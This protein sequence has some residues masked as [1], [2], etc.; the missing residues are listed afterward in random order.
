MPIP[1]VFYDW[2][3]K[4]PE[5]RAI[6]HSAGAFKADRMLGREV[7]QPLEISPRDW[8]DEVR[9]RLDRGDA[10]DYVE[11]KTIRIDWNKVYVLAGAPA[12]WPTENMQIYDDLLN[13]LT[14]RIEPR[15]D[16]EII[17]IKL[18]ADAFWEWRRLACEKSRVPARSFKHYQA[19]EL[20]QWRAMKRYNTALCQI[21]R[22]RKALGGEAQAI[23]RDF[24]AEPPIPERFLDGET[25]DEIGDAAAA[26]A[27]VSPDGVAKSGPDV[28]PADVAQDAADDRI[29]EIVEALR[30][31]TS[32]DEAA[33][34]APP[35][36]FAHEVEI[37]ERGATKRINWVAWLTGT[38]QYPFP[39]LEIAGEKVFK[40]TFH[41]RRALVRKLVLDC[42]II[43][44]DQVCPHFAEWLE[45]PQAP[46]TPD[47][48]CR[49]ERK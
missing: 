35:R 10:L 45:S 49:E 48:A 21:E 38:K 32:P 8:E 42:Q 2:V 14:R 1:L 37:K 13:V 29:W 39:E 4:H 41:T 15:N 40:Q 25:A 46:P 23:S 22:S 11:L 20:A 27:L 28:D 34:A 43:P 30:A 18:A 5:A 17:H 7:G 19:L 24:L 26:P 36:T 6:F 9:A 44:P 33:D 3:E 47:A 12:V 31:G 16:M